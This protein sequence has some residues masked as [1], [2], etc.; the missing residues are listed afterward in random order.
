MVYQRIHVFL[1][2]ARIKKH[3]KF[4]YLCVGCPGIGQSVKVIRYKNIE[5]I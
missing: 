3:N 2:N 4:K 5:S 1:G